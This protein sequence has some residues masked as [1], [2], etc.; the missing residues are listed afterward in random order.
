M[1]H[2]IVLF[3]ILLFSGCG[4]SEPDVAPLPS[5]QP[6]PGLELASAER[7]VLPGVHVRTMRAATE[8]AKPIGEDQTVI[9]SVTGHVHGGTDIV[10]SLEEVRWRD[11]PPAWRAALA[12]IAPDEVRRVWFCTPETKKDWGDAAKEP[13]VV[14]D[15]AIAEIR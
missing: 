4:A 12:G 5:Q 9:F 7:E 14:A 8:S 10:A 13:C 2:T 1:R 15:F 6:H 11:A 3:A